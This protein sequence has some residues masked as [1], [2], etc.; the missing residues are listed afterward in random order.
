MKARHVLAWLAI[1]TAV[2]VGC[3][4][5][6]GIEELSVEGDSG[7]VTPDA[8]A[9]D[10]G[11]DGMVNPSGVTRG[12]AR[13]MAC[14]Q[15]GKNGPMC[16]Q[17]CRDTASEMGSG[18][19]LEGFGRMTGCI[20]GDAGCAVQCAA[21]ICASPPVMGGGGMMECGGCID[22]RLSGPECAAARNSCK[23]S[24]QCAFMAACFEGCAN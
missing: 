2:I 6:L 7:A 17:C 22:G 12:I 9:G 16:L 3:R 10:G 13:A 20:C 18:G 1:A 4:G 8:T 19:Q 21:T 23:Q 11:T 5:V 14:K 15:D 24:A